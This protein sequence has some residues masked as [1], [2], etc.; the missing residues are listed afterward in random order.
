MITKQHRQIVEQL[1][2]I[3]RLAVALDRR[4]IGAIEQ[5]NCSYFPTQRELHLCLTPRQVDDDCALELW[6]LNFKKNVFESQFNLTVIGF[7]G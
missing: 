4:Q 1:N 3:L 5:V 6:S 2:A 7:L